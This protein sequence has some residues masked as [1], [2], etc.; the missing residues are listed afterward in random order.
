M[1][2]V[3]AAGEMPLTSERIGEAQA[4]V[5]G[6][7]AICTPRRANLLI[8]TS[9]GAAWESTREQATLAA[10]APLTA[11]DRSIHQ[12]QADALSCGGEGAEERPYARA[13]VRPVPSASCWMTSDSL[14]RNGSAF[15][16]YSPPEQAGGSNGFARSS[17]SAQV[18]SL[19]LAAAWLRFAW[20]H[21]HDGSGAGPGEAPTVAALVPRR[22]RCRRLR[23]E[24]QAP[25][26]ACHT[27]GQA[28]ALMQLNGRTC[29]CVR[30]LLLC[31]PPPA[32]PLGRP[33]RRLHLGLTLPLQLLPNLT[34]SLVKTYQSCSSGAE[35]A[36]PHISSCHAQQR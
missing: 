4:G 20:C 28:G 11:G 30:H 7:G 23:S 14:P 13:R 33:L 10:G 29:S 27:A 3:C 22:R 25:A 19:P 18:S 9:R 8:L 35:R 15:S 6:R 21:M 31:R 32:E 36:L 26:K 1:Q 24:A 12:F 5:A 16:A 2:G 17:S 34:V